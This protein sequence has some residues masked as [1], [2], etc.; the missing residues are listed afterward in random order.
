P[1]HWG[2]RTEP[3]R[4]RPVPFWRQGFA[5]LPETTPRVRVAA[6]PRRRAACSA[7][8]LWCTSACAKRVPKAPS[9]SETFSPAPRSGASGIAS[10][11]HDRAPWAGDRAA[12]HEQVA[13]AVDRDDLQPALGDAPVAHLAGPAHAAEDA[14]GGRRGADRARRADVV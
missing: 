6:V 5:P 11:L 12:H 8:T 3:A 9:S 14:R 10:D 1:V 2:A 4:A 13:L 7:R